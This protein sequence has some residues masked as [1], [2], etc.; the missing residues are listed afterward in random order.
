[1]KIFSF[2]LCTALLT[3]SNWALGSE[4][5]MPQLNPEF[6]AS[7]IFWLILIFSGLYFIIYKIF[8]PKIIYS[9]ENRKSRVVND[10]NEAQKLKEN[11]EIK[12]EEYNEI[13]EDSKKEAKKIIDDNKRKLDRDIE[14][15]KQKFNEEV[16]RELILTEKEIAALRK[17]SISDISEIA[18]EISIEVINQIINVEVN[19]SNVAAIVDETIKRKVE[20]YI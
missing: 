16:E 4:A 14:I 2:A 7:Q 5:G 3:Y 20:K 11:A 18:S 19:K 13:I 10:L 17:S 9:I 12:L 8:L 1:M 6:W 15:K